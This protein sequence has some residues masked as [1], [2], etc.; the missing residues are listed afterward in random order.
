MK[1]GVLAAHAAHLPAEL[2]QKSRFARRR[3][4]PTDQTYQACGR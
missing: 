4:H 2:V 1:L 3:Q